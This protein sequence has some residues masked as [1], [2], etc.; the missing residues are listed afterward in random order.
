MIIKDNTEGVLQEVDRRIT[1]GLEEVAPIVRDTAK[2]VVPVVTGKLQ[3]SIIAEIDDNKAII[4]SPVEYAPYVEM[5]KPY[6]RLALEKSKA[7]IKRTF[8][9]G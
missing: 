1:K 6:L 8:K 5:N 4:G 2:D 3:K 7:I 9:V